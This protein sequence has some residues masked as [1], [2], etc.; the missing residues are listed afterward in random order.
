MMDQNFG[1][2]TGSED[3]SEAREHVRAAEENRD[4]LAA[5][6]RR[7]GVT[8]TGTDAPIGSGG[9][10]H[11]PAG[12][13]RDLMDGAGP[14]RASDDASQA[15]ENVR[16]AEENRDALAD[17]KRRVESTLPPNVNTTGG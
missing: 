17:E 2:R 14:G 3:S 12:G 7:T 6:N 10:Q 13:G 4:A 9:V 16:A 1:S 5:Q 11:D 8:A 15:R